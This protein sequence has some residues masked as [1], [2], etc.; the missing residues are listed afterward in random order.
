MD[1]INKLLTFTPL[2][3]LY[4]KGLKKDNFWPFFLEGTAEIGEEREKERQWRLK[5]E[6][7]KRMPWPSFKDS[8][9]TKR[10][11]FFFFPNQSMEVKFKSCCV[12]RPKDSAFV[13]NKKQRGFFVLKKCKLRE[14]VFFTEWLNNLLRILVIL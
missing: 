14:K 1:Y 7:L 10:A 4:I 11:I 9:L 8:I 2:I 3:L 6:R 12:S 5:K 13:I